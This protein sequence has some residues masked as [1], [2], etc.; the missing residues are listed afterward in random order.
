[1]VR[2]H[3]P[4]AVS[5]TKLLGCIGYLSLAKSKAGASFGSNRPAKTVD[6]SGEGQVEPGLS[7]SA[8][9]SSSSRGKPRR[10]H[11]STGRFPRSPANATMWSAARYHQHLAG[12]AGNAAAQ[13]TMPTA[14]AAPVSSGEPT[15]EATVKTVS[16]PTMKTVGEGTVKTVAEATVKTRKSSRH[17]DS[18][19]EPE[20]PRL[21][22]PIRIIE[23]IGVIV[24]IRIAI[25]IF[26]WRGDHVN[27]WRQ[28]RRSLGDPP[29]PIRL[30]AG[31]DD[32]LL[33]LSA[34]RDRNGV[35]GAR[36]LVGRRL[37]GVG[38]GRGGLGGRWNNIR[39]G[40]QVGGVL[41]DMPATVRLSTRP[42][43]CLL[44]PS[45]DRYRRGEV[46]AVELRFILRQLR[47][48]W[49]RCDL[50]RIGLGL[51]SCARQDHHEGRDRAHGSLRPIYGAASRRFR[52]TNTP[53]VREANR[54]D[55]SS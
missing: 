42:G 48:A 4:P 8:G 31:F 41:H 14:A 27:L 49:H 50:D 46:A 16:E 51:A 30:L 55:R 34:Y 24:R 40:G 43:I 1:M 39:L 36:R 44:R 53:Y 2:I 33:L 11:P 32:R 47:F 3:L 7:T 23:R 17:H 52:R 10:L 35:A 18:G 5:R 38:R 26:G 20:K 15:A 21:G 19:P 13:L 22:G 45:S 54:A 29:A 25:G 28:S 9:R 6:D 12:R 37:R